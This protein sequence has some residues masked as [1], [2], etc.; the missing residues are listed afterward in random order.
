[1]LSVVR[2][3]VAHGRPVVVESTFTRVTKADNEQGKMTY[4][5]ETELQHILGL[6]D[7]RAFAIQLFAP[8]QVV[9]SRLMAT[10]RLDEWVVEGTWDAHRRPWAGC[11]RLDGEQ[12]PSLIA[13]QI[14]AA[15]WGTS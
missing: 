6:H 3:L 14:D 5:H 10:R 9:R 11:L 7:D 12:T 2:G 1:M 13:E 15:I 8:W 4:V